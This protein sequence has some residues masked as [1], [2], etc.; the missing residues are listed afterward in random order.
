MTETSAV[1]L[2]YVYNELTETG[3]WRIIAEPLRK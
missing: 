3:D 2:F 1:A